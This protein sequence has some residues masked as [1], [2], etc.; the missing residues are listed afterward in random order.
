MNFSRTHLW[1]LGVMGIFTGM[2]APVVSN[3]QWSY[4]FPLTSLQFPTYIIL[5]S[6][7]IACILLSVRKWWGVKWL[8]LV[9]LVC[10]SYM[11]MV[12]WWGEVR[13]NKWILA[14]ELSWGWI[15]IGIWLSMLMV[16]AMDNKNKI[17]NKKLHLSDH[18]IWWTSSLTILGLTGL[19]ISIS[20]TP[21]IDIKTG[22]V[23]QNIFG[24]TEITTMSWISYTKSFSGIQNLIFDRKNDKLSFFTNN[25]DNF[26]KYPE[27]YI[28]SWTG[29]R[30]IIINWAE[31]IINWDWSIYTPS[32]IN[33][34]KLIWI[35]E[36]DNSIMLSTGNTLLSIS[37]NGIQSFTWGNEQ[38]KNTAYNKASNQY[39]WI[40]KSWTGN[41]IFINGKKYENTDYDVIDN[42]LV[43]DGK[44]IMYLSS[45]N[46]KSVIIKNWSPI[47]ELPNNIIL[48]TLQFNWKN[49]I[50]AIEQDWSIWLVYNGILLDRKFDEIREIYLDKNSDWFVYFGRPLWEKTY[51]LYTRYRGNICWITGYMNPRLSA[52]ESSVVY[53]AIKDNTWWIYRNASPIISNTW[54]P[55]NTS[56]TDDYVFF[57]ITNPSYYLFIHKTTEGYKLYKKWWWMAWIWQDVGLDTIFWYDNK[58]IMS[59]KDREWWRVIEF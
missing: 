56:I 57:D 42:S 2:I 34:W 40:T 41:D 46:G 21:N 55:I 15:F 31:Y 49:F 48:K 51:C 35:Y 30:N 54:Y 37:D 44:N 39:I 38:I 47:Q 59:V 18:I 16:S 58:I 53:A 13:T 17:P 3:T 8:I 24:E 20:Y 33:I 22:K 25:G 7:A 10:I 6:L 12:S 36:K 4:A 32:S 1:M 9:I 14:Q 23:L 26:K 19:I 43:F 11:F 27:G 28:F 5:L 52:D 45:K 29:L 50:Y